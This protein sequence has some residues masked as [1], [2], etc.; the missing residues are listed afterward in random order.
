MTLETTTADNI[1]THGDAADDISLPKS[2]SARFITAN[3]KFPMANRDVAQ[4]QDAEAKYRGIFENA[5]EG[6]YQSTPDGRYIAVNPAMARMYGYAT[7]EE[8]MH[9]VSDIQNQIYVDPA[10]RERFQQLMD[11]SDLVRGLEYEVRRRDGTTLWI[12]ESA[13]VVRD[14]GG[15]VRYYEG[16]ID[17]ITQRKEAEAARTRLEKQM[18]QAQKMEAVGLLAG[19]I[20]HDFNNI[21]C[22]MLGFTDLALADQQVAG[23]TRRN[24]QQVLRSA[25]RASDL[26]KRILTFSRSSEIKQRPLRLGPLLR[27]SAKL[28]NA[29][30][31]SSITVNIN[32]ETEADTIIADPTEIHQVIMNL[33]TNAGHAMRQTGGRLEFNVST[34]Q[35]TTGQASRMPPLRPGPHLCLTIKDT[36][37][38]MSREVLERIFDPFFTTKPAGEGTGLGL[39]LV[40]TIVGHCGG[41]MTLESHVGLGTTFW[42]YFPHDPNVA[43]APEEN[44][45]R[46][47]PG[48]REWLLVVDDEPVIL[49]LMQQ[50]LRKMNYRVITR[51][52][53]AEAFDTFR[54]DPKRF[55][56]VITDHTMPCLQGAELAGELGKIR[57]DLPVILMT[58]LSCLPDLSGSPFAACRAVIR[59][60][61]DFPDLSR[62]LRQFIDRP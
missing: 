58:G 52:D 62:R 23:V 45:P 7:P 46:I 36:G 2:Q 18:V 49:H 32:M 14:A 48:H 56:A 33:G 35:L 57:S 41:Y 55:A 47:V 43:V 54:K 39:T 10:Q 1:G 42:I 53:S 29:A 44:R 19:G 21:L 38:G 13:R 9:S 60:P 25:E 26:I 20:A 61:V 5:V 31:P 27:E 8:L 4:L 17:D 15:A 28:L 6:I 50:Y 37:H 51:A 11:K 12:S 30:L 3:L 22:A 24:L 59:K 34:L 40:Q 16:F